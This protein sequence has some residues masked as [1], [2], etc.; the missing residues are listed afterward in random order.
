MA[1]QYAPPPAVDPTMGG[2]CGA[3]FRRRGNDG[4]G[5]NPGRWCLCLNGFGAARADDILRDVIVSFAEDKGS[6]TL[7]RISKGSPT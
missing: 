2:C 3:F 5:S 6:V 1:S 7:N 4:D